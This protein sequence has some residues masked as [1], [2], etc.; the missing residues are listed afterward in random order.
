MKELLGR[1]V[2]ELQAQYALVRQSG[3]R[4]G[5]SLECEEREHERTSGADT[6]GQT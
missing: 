3:R 2:A 1:A 6:S 5:G 4:G